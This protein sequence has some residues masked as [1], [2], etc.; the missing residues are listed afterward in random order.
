MKIHKKPRLDVIQ[1]LSTEALNAMDG[2]GI[3]D[4]TPA[5]VVS[6]CFTLTKRVCK[7]ILEESDKADLE[8]NIDQMQDAIGSLFAILPERTKH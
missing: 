1:L 2:A 8:N 5:E 4:I 7:T 3:D 6:A